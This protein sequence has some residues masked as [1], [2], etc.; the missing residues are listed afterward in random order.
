MVAVITIGSTSLLK[1]VQMANKLD[2]VW[3]SDKGCA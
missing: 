2:K 1:N 3:E